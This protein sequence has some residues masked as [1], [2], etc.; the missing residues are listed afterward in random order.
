MNRRMLLLAGVLVVLVVIF[1]NPFKDQ[2]KRE[3]RD[4]VTVF[5]AEKVKTADRIEVGT[6]TD[7]SLKI[8]PI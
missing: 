3:K 7:S 5:D 8:L 6:A 2:L 4:W 1:A